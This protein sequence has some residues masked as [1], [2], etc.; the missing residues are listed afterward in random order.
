[1]EVDDGSYEMVPIGNDEAVDETTSAGREEDEEDISAPTSRTEYS[2]AISGFLIL[3]WRSP[4]TP[5]HVSIMFL[6]RQPNASLSS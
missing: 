6:G 5:S 4:L 1:M 2:S 3:N